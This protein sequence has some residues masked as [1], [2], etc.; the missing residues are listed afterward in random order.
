MFVVNR[1]GVAGAD[2][3]TH[4]SLIHSLSQ[5]SFSS[6]SSKYH[7]SQTVKARE[8]KFLE[9]GNPPQPVTCLHVTCHILHVTCHELHD[10]FLDIVVKLIG[11]GSDINWAYPV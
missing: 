11:G 8:L 4:S 2:L 10:I 6:K 5:L 1:T 7:K 9:N 3:R